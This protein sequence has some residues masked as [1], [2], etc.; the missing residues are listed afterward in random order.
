[1]NSTIP[2]TVHNWVVGTP[3][4]TFGSLRNAVEFAGHFASDLRA[5]EILI[6]TGNHQYRIIS[7]R[8]LALMIT[9]VNAR[10]LLQ[11]VLASEVVNHK[12]VDVGCVKRLDEALRETR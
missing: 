8:E 11:I 10:H 2:I 4:R 5:I 6:H 12:M 1:M 7:G 3:N 9:Q